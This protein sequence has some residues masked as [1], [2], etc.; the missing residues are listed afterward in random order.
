MEDLGVVVL[1]EFTFLIEVYTE[2]E[3]RLRCLPAEVRLARVEIYQILFVNLDLLNPAF[4]LKSINIQT[5]D[6]L[7]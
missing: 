3:D 4:I 7:C 2:K 1:N 5:N 6:L